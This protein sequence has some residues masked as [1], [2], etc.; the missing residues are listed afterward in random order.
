VEPAAIG[1]D[2]EVAWSAHLVIVLVFGMLLAGCGGAASEVEDIQ[3]ASETVSDET[4]Q[5]IFVAAPETSGSWPVVVLLHGTGG[6]GPGMA[7]FANALAARGLVV[8]APTYRS[9]MSTAQGVSELQSDL[10]C[11]YRYVVSHAGEFG[12]DL[13]QPLTFVGHS[14]GA[15]LV[16]EGG[17]TNESSPTACGAEVPLAQIVVAISGCHYQFE[18]A[19]FGFDPSGWGNKEATVIL[20]GGDRDETCAAWQSEDAAAALR[21]AGYNVD[22]EILEG[23]NHLSPILEDLVDGESVPAPDDPAGLETID[24]ISEAIHAQ[25]DR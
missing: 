20:L 11:A 6:T 21:S 25:T 23:A 8:F 1:Q 18:D 15:S 14:L 12:G 5:E 4:T 3:V 16:L 9:D 13:D 24:I 19:R 2:G 10:T 22:L 17:L 7:G